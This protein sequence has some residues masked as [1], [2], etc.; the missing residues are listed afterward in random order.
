M[1]RI[2]LGPLAER[3]CVEGLAADL[4]LPQAS[5]LYAASDGNPLYFLALLQAHRDA[6]KAPGRTSPSRAE[7]CRENRA[8]RRSGSARCCWTSWHP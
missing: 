7:R 3:D 6:R 2:A 5:E 4:P 8:A 1:L